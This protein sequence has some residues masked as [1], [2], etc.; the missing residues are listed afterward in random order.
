MRDRLKWCAFLCRLRY[1]K[2]QPR[3]ML[4]SC[5]PPRNG[6]AAGEI[7]TLQGNLNWVA[8]REHSLRHP[9]WGGRE[10]EFLPLTSAKQ[11]QHLCSC[12]APPPGSSC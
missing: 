5:E 12:S 8:S 11:V 6:C 2:Q 1:G 4:H 3:D 7:N 9:V 10:H